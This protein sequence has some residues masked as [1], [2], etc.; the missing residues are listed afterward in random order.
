MSKLRSKTTISNRKPISANQPI[1]TLQ[2]GDSV[3]VKGATKDPD[4][5]MLIG[6]WQGRVIRL[7]DDRKHTQLVHIQ[8][9]SITLGGMDG[10][11]IAECERRD[12]DWSQ[13]VLTIHEVDPAVTRDTPRD[14]GRAVKE[15][16]SRYAWIGLGEE[17]ERIQ[18]VLTGI[19][20]NDELKAMRAWRKYLSQHLKFPFEAEISEFQEHGPLHAGDRVVVSSISGL[21][22]QYG[23]IAGLRVGRSR[24]DFPLCDLEVTDKHSPNYELVHDYA[25]WFVNR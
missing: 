23:V 3:V 2:V 16:S 19:A 4:L 17:G 24:N 25:V 8:W 22:D 7:E 5:G 6:G 12:L 1:V 9:D 10:S 15:L 20:Q 13:M 21:D 14:V 18:R 11:V